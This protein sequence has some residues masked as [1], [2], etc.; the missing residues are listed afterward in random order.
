M[1][2][3]TGASARDVGDSAVLQFLARVGLLA[4]GIVHVIIGILAFQI[5]WGAS[6]Q[7]SPDLI[8]ALRSLRDQPLGGVLLW[9]AVVGF[10]ALALW[11]ASEAVVGHRDRE[12]F[13]RLR[14]RVASSGKAVLHAAIGFTAISISL[15]LGT[16]DEQSKEDAISGVMAWPGGTVIVV[17]AVLIT[18]G[19]GVAGVTRGITMSFRE[20][21]D[22]SSMS[23]GARTGLERLGQVGFVVKGVVLCLVGGMVGYAAL[24]FD[25]EQAS[26]LNDAVYAIL[27]QPF[28]RFLLTAMALGFAAFGLFSIGSSRYRQM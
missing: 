1:S 16:S 20:Q 21:L 3:R 14:M 23:K 25:Q 26:G 15:G 19:I 12:G 27:A 10:A 7:E 17:V 4:W 28:G 11:Q 9:I 13:E 24:T 2:S 6:T 18:I 5:A 8:G 22:T